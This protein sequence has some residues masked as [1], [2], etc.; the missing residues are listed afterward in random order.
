[1]MTAQ[2]VS[3][4]DCMTISL[5]RY[6]DFL[7]F[8]IDLPK[9]EKYEIRSKKVLA[10]IVTVHDYVPYSQSTNNLSCTFRARRSLIN[11][12]QKF[13]YT[14]MVLDRARITFGQF[15]KFLYEVRG[16]MKKHDSLYDAFI[17]AFV[18]H[19][20]EHSIML[21][22]GKAYSRV[23]LYQYFN[24]DNCR[25]FKKKTKIMLFEACK[26]P[27]RPEHIK[28]K[29]RVQH[30]T[31]RVQPSRHPDDR[32]AIFESNSDGY[33]SFS[34]GGRGALIS[35]FIKVMNSIEGRLRLDDMKVHI[36]LEIEKIRKEYAK[37]QVLNARMM[38]FSRI[39]YF[40]APE[41]GAYSL[42]YTIHTPT[43]FSLLLYNVRIYSLCIPNATHGLDRHF[44]SDP[45]ES[46][47]IQCGRVLTAIIT[48][49]EYEPY[50]SKQNNAPNT[51]ADR[52]GLI[53]LFRSHYRYAVD[54]LVQDR[55]TLDDFKEFIKDV[56]AEMIQNH[57]KYDA[58]IFAF[59]GH[60]NEG[61][62]QLS[63][64]GGYGRVDIYKYFNAQNCPEF[65]DKLKLFLIDTCK[66][67]GHA[68]KSSSRTRAVIRN[69]QEFGVHCPTH[70]DSNIAIFSSNNQGG[71]GGA[72]ISSFIKVMRANR[73][74]LPLDKMK[75]YI[76]RN[77]RALSK[78]K[79]TKTMPLLDCEMMGI[80]KDIYF[81]A[82]KYSAANAVHRM[83]P[84]LSA[85][86]K[87]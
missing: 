24:G 27:G 48:V 78:M 4:S 20:H 13:G 46:Y 41:Y 35:S 15:N 11:L 57:K 65:T 79:N 31:K 44:H 36:Q 17:F 34:Y 55:I 60:G 39:M 30:H 59:S 75:K 37:L 28:S 23:D 50:H 62:I 70:Q 68:M 82:P 26:L 81:D 54:R 66:G 29:R 85:K 52:E 10:A 8:H 83:A 64:G 40:C 18:G 42:M 53:K 76:Q 56:R 16:M 49:H 77:V 61:S 86:V 80:E 45:L 87:G 43:P 9:L 12:F 51:V 2:K 1:M 72:L 19:G 25:E 58:F 22:D 63:D 38:G 3:I 14:V 67:D 21:S 71:G 74:K 84:S 32:I 6:M 7:Y 33:E 73:H 69:G 5:D 47:N